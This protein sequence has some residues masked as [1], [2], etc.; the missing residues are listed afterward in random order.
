MKCFISSSEYTILYA[1]LRILVHIFRTIYISNI[2]WKYVSFV[3]NNRD[4]KTWG[5]EVTLKCKKVHSSKNW[6]HKR[7]VGWDNNVK[8]SKHGTHK[9]I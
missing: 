8:F 5:L 7:C 9:L 4:D 2:K 1:H 6:P 3:S